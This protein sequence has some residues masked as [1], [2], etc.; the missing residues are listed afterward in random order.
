MVGK[1]GQKGT[2]AGW[3]SH[4]FWDC[5]FEWMCFINWHHQGTRFLGHIAQLIWEQDAALMRATHDH[6]WLNIWRWSMILLDMFLKT[7]GPTTQV[8]IIIWSVS[9]PS[10]ILWALWMLSIFLDYTIYQPWWP[11]TLQSC[12]FLCLSHAALANNIGLCLRAFAGRTLGPGPAL[13]W[14]GGRSWCVQYLAIT[15]N[16]TKNQ[17]RVGS[18]FWICFIKVIHKYSDELH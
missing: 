4:T 15:K 1:H 11:Q 10:W 16:L 6:K 7:H 8:Q 12:V 3:S 17:L 5:L 18:M 9:I 13:S 14:L 2:D